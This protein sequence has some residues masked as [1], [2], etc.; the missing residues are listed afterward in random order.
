VLP[1]KI[2]LPYGCRLPN[3]KMRVLATG[4]AGFVGKSLLSAL[5][6]KQYRVS[7][8]TRSHKHCSSS[9]N[10]HVV[11]N[12]DAL[13]NWSE[14]LTGTDAVI[15]LAA[16]VHVMRDIA[17]NPLA[18][19]RRVNVDGTLNL[20]RQ[21]AAIGVRR[22]IFLSTI[23]VNGNST[24]LG[25]A[26]SENDASLPHD[27]YSV[28][29]HEAEVGLRSISKSTGMELVII[30]PTLV[31]GS[32]APGNFGKLT[33]LVAKGLPLPLASIDNRRSLVGVDNLI[34]FIVTCLEHPSAGNET[35]LVSDGED[36]ST[37]DLIR[38][39][40]RAMDRPARLLPVPKS[41]LIAAAAMLGQSDMAQ[42][43]CGSLQ[44]DISKSRELLGWNP[45]VS[46]DE[47]L[48]RAV[49]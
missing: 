27:P 24:T 37:P 44:V 18:E 2:M 34:S 49:K 38:R 16:R 12:I 30:R 31:H 22:F 13:T 20:A 47:G 26:F 4:S 25:T 45:P 1:I 29:K 14:A 46:V 8:A 33:R 43:L 6:A 3:L 10:S 42:R 17:R 7:A 28:S 9:F 23:G 21:A 5:D 11:G 36:L 15:H 32:R 39:M 40:A 41:V 35:F 19:F 48:R